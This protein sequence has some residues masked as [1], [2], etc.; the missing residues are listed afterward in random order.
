[1]TVNV[2]EHH[3]DA[4]TRVSDAFREIAPVAEKSRVDDLLNLLH[5][6]SFRVH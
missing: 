4:A 2:Y 6:N 3:V 5:N 1:M